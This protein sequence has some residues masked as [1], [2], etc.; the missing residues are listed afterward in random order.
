MGYHFFENI[1]RWGRLFQIRALPLSR[2]SACH[3]SLLAANFLQ[4]FYLNLLLLADIFANFLYF[5][6]NLL[7]YFVELDLLHW[8]DTAK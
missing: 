6:A 3:G 2:H 1:Y 5:L 4:L 8:Q 7:P